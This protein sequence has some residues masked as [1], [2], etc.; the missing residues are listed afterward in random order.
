MYLQ[1]DLL[2]VAEFIANACPGSR[3]VLKDIADELIPKE[4]KKAHYSDRGDRVKK[5]DNGSRIVIHTL[6]F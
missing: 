6:P 4:Y 2:P 1:S 3:I 5:F